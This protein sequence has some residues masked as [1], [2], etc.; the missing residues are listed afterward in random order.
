MK[1]APPHVPSGGGPRRSAMWWGCGQIVP[2]S[3]RARGESHALFHFA[4]WVSS[5]SPSTRNAAAELL[6]LIIFASRSAEPS[7]DIVCWD[8]RCRAYTWNRDWGG[9]KAGRRAVLHP[10]WYHRSLAK[11]VPRSSYLLCPED[12]L[13]FCWTEGTC[14]SGVK[15]CTKWVS[16]QSMVTLSRPVSACLYS[17]SF[18][19]VHR[20]LKLKNLKIRICSW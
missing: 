13:V 7:G 10:R 8:M 15:V 18:L 1:R 12:I 9:E 19:V 16:L 4:V 5:L 14:P 3:I 2:C 17:L 20:F 6:P 11:T